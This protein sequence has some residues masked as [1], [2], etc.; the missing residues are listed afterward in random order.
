MSDINL[1]AFLT[2]FYH[3]I[4]LEKIEIVPLTKKITITTTTTTT[5]ATVFSSLKFAFPERNQTTLITR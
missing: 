4:K 1:R 2:A 5:L 3:G